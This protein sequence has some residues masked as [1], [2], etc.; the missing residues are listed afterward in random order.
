MKE[1]L[2]RNAGNEWSVY[3]VEC[4]DGT[5]YTGYTITPYGGYYYAASGSNSGATNGGNVG[6]CMYPTTQDIP[7]KAV[8][9]AS[10]RKVS[11]TQYQWTPW[12]LQSYTGSNN[13]NH[14]HTIDTLVSVLSAG[15]Y[16]NYRVIDGIANSLGTPATVVLP[17][18]PFDDA[19][20]PLDTVN[21][22]ATGSAKF[23]I[24]ALVVTVVV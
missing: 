16:S 15:M 4:A 14:N 6:L 20:F 9:L 10:F 1:V 8:M 21:L 17:V 18:Q 19:N 2:K 24:Y 13:S 3:I 12:W 22:Y 5:L 7:R 11:A 23:R